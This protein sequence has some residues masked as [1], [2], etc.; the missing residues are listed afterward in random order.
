MSHVNNFNRIVA[1]NHAIENLETIALND[2]GADT[3]D[4]RRL[5]CFAVPA[6]ELYRGVDRGQNIDSA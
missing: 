3:F 4:P 6:D 1:L 5:S 2:L